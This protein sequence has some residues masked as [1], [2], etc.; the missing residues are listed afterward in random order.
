MR[1]SVLG[2]GTDIGGSIRIPAICNGTYAIKPSVGRI[3]YGGQTSSARKGLEG[4]KPC[5]GPLATST[6]DLSLL[7][8]SVLNSDPWELDSSVIFNPWRHATSKPILRLGYILEDPHFPVHPPVLRTLTSATEK[9]K[10]AGH[11]IIPL[12]PPS[13]KDA[14]LL[15]FRCFAM[16]PAKTAF[17]HIGVSGEPVIPALASTKLPN[18][19]MPYEYAPLTLESLYDLTEQ[20]TWYKERFRELMVKNRIDAIIMPGNQG[21]AVAHDQYGWVPYTVLWNVMDVG[22]VNE[23][24][25]RVLTLL[26]S[27][28]YYPARQGRQTCRRALCTGRGVST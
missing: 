16:D 24:A 1:G 6:R 28:V 12:E 10:Q 2:M 27:G 23:D 15:A 3:P 4:I 8:Q 19:D 7:L 11:E 9:L 5:A 21:T 22:T 13:I 14:C 26:V 25:A 20:R 17:K 18:E